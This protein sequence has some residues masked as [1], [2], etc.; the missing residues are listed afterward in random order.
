MSTFFNKLK[1]YF[2]SIFP[3]LGQKH[4]EKAGSFKRHIIWVCKTMPKFRKNTDPFIL[5]NMSR[6]ATDFIAPFP[7]L[8]GPVSEIIPLSYESISLSQN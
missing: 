1:L 4:H 5:K 8:G 3:I 7:L 2:W 6:W